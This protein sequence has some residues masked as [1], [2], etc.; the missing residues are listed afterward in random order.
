VECLCDLEIGKEKLITKGD[1]VDLYIE[2]DKWDYKIYGD[3]GGRAT[4]FIKYCP[5]CG[6]KLFD[7]E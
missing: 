4:M 1:W 3:G 5:E 7:D 2:R 6:R